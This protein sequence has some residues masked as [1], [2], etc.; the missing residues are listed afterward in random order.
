ME[1]QTKQRATR[2]RNAKQSSK[3]KRPTPQKEQNSVPQIQ[4]LEIGSVSPDPVQPRKTFDAQSLEHLAHS[5]TEHGVLQPITVRKSDDGYIIVM[6]E[7]RYRASKLAGLTTIPAMVRDY[8]DTEVLEVQIIENLQRKDVE[9]TEEAEAIQF[10]LDRY[11][12]GEIAKRLGRSENYVRQRIKLAGLIEG[13]KAFVRTGEMTISLAVAVALFEPDEQQMMLD[14]L[15]GD[16]QGHRI[17]R[18]IESRTYDLT[19]ACF[20]VTDKT[21][22]TKAGACTL[23]PFNAAN[24]GN[25]FG[26]GKMICTRTSCFE[27][28]KTKTFMQLLKRVKKEGLKL[29]PNISKYWVDEERNQWVMAQMEKEGLEVHLTN[30]L[31]ILKQPIEPTLEN[32]KEEHRHYE[33]TEEELAE[34]LSE[35]LES[36]T[37]KK[38]AWDNAIDHGFEKGILLETD[39]YL[40]QAIFVRVREETNQGSSGAKSL[41]KRKMS[42][43][44]PGEQIIKINARE[45]RKKQIEN[46]NQFKEVVDMVRDTDYIN[47]KKPLS[48]DEMVAISISLFENNIG[49]YSQRE[50]FKDFFG[51]DS[52]LSHEELVA[53]FKENFKKE[54]LYK[55]LRFLLTRQVH[56]GESNHTNDLTNRSFYVAM[57][58]FYNDKISVID[59]TYAESRQKREARI[60]E[61]VTVLEQQ[62]KAIED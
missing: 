53:R 5:I 52:R 41:E 12:P 51:D 4:I 50:H 46:N 21:L 24:Q 30:E 43:C 22:V 60:K 62:A 48:T 13:F 10:L 35:A 2:K 29:V 14:S 27:N 49:F 31:D 44:T 47:R 8:V 42:E 20:D 3:P 33:Y 26:E 1:A 59:E 19:K 6:G 15:E 39:T 34:F 17:K 36:F 54:T 55:L 23:C 57:Q 38:E 56:L 18:M 9:P 25:L 11:E 28:K 61:R 37:E 16:F 45:M 7:R 58:S 32:I 40:T